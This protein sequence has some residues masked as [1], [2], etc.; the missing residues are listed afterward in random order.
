M[1]LYRW[2]LVVHGCIDGYSRRI[3]YLHCS[4]NNCASTVKSLFVDGVRDCGLPKR[5]RSD[6]G[7]E[8]VQVA[9]FML[10]HPSRGP[11]SG[12]FITG[13]SVHNQ[14]IE[15]L[16]RDVFS[17]CTILYHRLFHFMESIGVLDIDNE[18]HLFTL[19]YVYLPRINR[20]LCAFKNGWNNHPLSSEGHMTPM[21]MW[22]SGLIREPIEEENLSEV[23][24]MYAIVF[25]ADH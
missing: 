17:Q 13:R 15:R 5:V 23:F 14:R 10:E 1:S 18:T 11:E 19:H 22:I 6:R 9:R 16:W 24:L 12:S 25:Q 7:G 21:Q 4:D 20:S 3:I 8:N 2:R